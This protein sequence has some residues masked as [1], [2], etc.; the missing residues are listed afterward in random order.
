MDENKAFGAKVR[1]HKAGSECME[2]SRTRSYEL[3]WEY[4]LPPGMETRALSS[5]ESTVRFAESSLS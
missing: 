5:P 1:K 2:A 4:T 3:P